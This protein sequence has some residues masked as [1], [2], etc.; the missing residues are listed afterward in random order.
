MTVITAIETA[1]QVLIV[2][3]KAPIAGDVKT[4][5][6]PYLSSLEAANL[7]KCFVSDV[8]KNASQLSGLC[9][10]Q[11]AYQP[12]PKASDL[13]WLGL[14]QTPEIFRQ[15]GRS[16]GERLTHAFGVA[17]GKGAKQVVILGSDA[18]TLPASFI[19]KAYDELH[20]S[21]VVLGPA[22]DGGYYLVGLSRPCLKLFEEVSWSTDQ[23]FERTTQNAMRYGYSLKILPTHYDI[24]TIEDLQTLHQELVNNGKEAPQTKR[25]LFDL[26][27]KNQLF[28][29]V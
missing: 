1:K 2:F 27:R 22:T 26:I 12:H 14:R 28:S 19:E 24:D 8:I 6:I 23:V 20:S 13:S 29:S 3:V 11:V 21:D 17:F 18:P 25:Y 9:R 15:E 5:L 4:R 10:I 7:Y 16:L